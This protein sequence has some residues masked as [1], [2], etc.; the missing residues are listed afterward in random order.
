MSKNSGFLKQNFVATSL[1]ALTALIPATG[2]L[3][4]IFGGSTAHAQDSAEAAT[5][6]ADFNKTPVSI[7]QPSAPTPEK[8]DTSKPWE[9]KAAYRASTGRIVLHYGKGILDADLLAEGLS[10]QGYPTIAVPGGPEGKI[11]MFL[12]R[13]IPGKYN[14]HDLDSGTLGAH[15]TRLFDKYVR[16]SPDPNAVSL[17]K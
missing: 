13:K 12:D 6:P 9:R 10:E 4:N 2:K 8:I 5:L 17:A 16:S 1:V 11:E 14:Q 3:G 15:A 7:P